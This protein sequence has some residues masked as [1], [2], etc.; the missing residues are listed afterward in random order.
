[1]AII[2][3]SADVLALDDKIRKLSDLRAECEALDVTA[4]TLVGGG[5]SIYLL[6]GIDEE[7]TQLKAAVL[8]LLDNSVG[9]FKNVRNSMVEVDNEAARQLDSGVYLA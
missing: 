6:N 9:F 3:I 4:K 5:S 8:T 2:R 7:Y 1:M